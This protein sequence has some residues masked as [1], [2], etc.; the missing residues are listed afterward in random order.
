MKK[1]YNAP[2]VELIK[3]DTKDIMASSYSISNDS[4]GKDIFSK[5]G[6]SIIGGVN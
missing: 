3:L 1:L 5:N 2:S 6:G 4:W